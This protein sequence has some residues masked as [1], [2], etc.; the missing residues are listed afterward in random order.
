MLGLAASAGRLHAAST[1]LALGDSYAF[2]FETLSLVQ[3]TYGDQGYVKVYAD[4]LGTPAGGGGGVRPNVINLAIPG[5]DSFSFSDTTEFGRIANLNYF[6][7]PDAI[8]QYDLMLQTIAAEQLAGNTIDHVSFSLGGN[9]L[10]GLANDASFLSLT[11]SQQQALVLT[12]LF[13]LTNNFALIMDAVR[14]LLPDAEI[15]VVGYF[16]PFLAVPD[17]PVFNASDP[18]ADLLNQ[19][20]SGVAGAFDARYVDIRP[21]FAGREGELSWI[22]TDPPAGTNIHPTAE[23]YRLIGET[24]IVPGPGG[25]GMLALAGVAAVRRRRRR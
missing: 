7:R 2:G 22:L 17:S 9:D 16:N 23:G 14:G 19:V 6:N 20:V 25:I 3:Q 1:Y 11:P 4:W 10:L 24:M 18:A 8:S 5:E 15:V 21:V 12:R 13:E